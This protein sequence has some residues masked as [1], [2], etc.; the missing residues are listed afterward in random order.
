M[1][2]KEL[3]RQ[4]NIPNVN[5]SMK[6]NKYDIHLIDI[7]ANKISII[8]EIKALLCLG[9]KEAKALVDS[10]SKVIK[11]QVNKLEADNMK[12]KLEALGASIQL[13]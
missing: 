6:E 5:L 11:I 3:P 2:S 9:L 1:N 8:K 7:G 4:D 13:T 10:I 12:S